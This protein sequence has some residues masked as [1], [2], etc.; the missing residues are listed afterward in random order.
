MSG[1]EEP[2]YVARARAL[3]NE[4]QVTE[5]AGE[6]LAGLRKDGDCAEAKIL[7]EEI[8]DG[9]TTSEL[10][11]KEKRAAPA[12]SA[13]VPG[14]NEAAAVGGM[15]TFEMTPEAEAEHEWWIYWF[16]FVGASLLGV[17]LLAGTFCSVAVSPALING[18]L[19]LCGFAS[20]VVT[21]T[22]CCRIHSRHERYQPDVVIPI[23]SELGI[24]EP[25]TVRLCPRPRS[26][27][28]LSQHSSS[29]LHRLCLTCSRVI[30]IVLTVR[31]FVCSCSV[32]QLVY[33]VGFTLVGVLLG[34][35]IYRFQET[36][37]SEQ[38]THLACI[39]FCT[40]GCEQ[41]LCGE[42]E[43]HARFCVSKPDSRRHE[44]RTASSLA[45]QSLMHVLEHLPACL[46]AWLPDCLPGYRWFRCC[47]VTAACRQTRAVAL[48]VL[49]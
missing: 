29:S 39:L 31:L 47:S 43:T 41:E 27:R 38:S 10:L 42:R 22:L 49:S 48:P 7:L 8:F 45:Y 12:D 40:T 4:K 20:F 35:S 24:M 30:T 28:P 15:V 36:V 14:G 32:L 21:M 37:P 5:A 25:G 6:L 1:A 11:R 33:Q 44:N 46:P 2:A 26:A 13:D 17:L 23:I 19:P 18:A 34:G 16:T 9:H 3:I